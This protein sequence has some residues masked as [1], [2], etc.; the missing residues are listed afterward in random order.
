MSARQREILEEAAIIEGRTLTDFI[1]TH[2]QEA[3][4]R[5]I[6]EHRLLRLSERD[7][8]VFFTALTDSWEPGEE[9]R[10]DLCRMRGLFDGA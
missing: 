8:R 6:Q 10:E 1:L 3:A 9:L 4:R 2:A 7:A 5:T